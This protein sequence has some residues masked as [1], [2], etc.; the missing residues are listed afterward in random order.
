MRLEDLTAIG[1]ASYWPE[2]AGLFV[3]QKRAERILKDADFFNS[4]SLLAPCKKT[5]GQVYRKE[6]I[7][8]ETL[9]Y[10]F[11][12]P[13]ATWSKFWR[14][15]MRLVPALMIWL[16]LAVW[17]LLFGFGA[18]IDL[19]MT[20]VISRVL[21]HKLLFIETAASWLRITKVAVGSHGGHSQIRWVLEVAGPV[22]ALGDTHP[23][24]SH[25][26]FLTLSNQ[27]CGGHDLCTE[28]VSSGQSLGAHSP[29]HSQVTHAAQCSQAMY[30]VRSKVQILVGHSGRSISRG[31]SQMCGTN[32][33]K[34]CKATRSR[35]KAT[36]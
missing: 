33:M 7:C 20:G 31:G 18:E 28:P 4:W 15:G 17:T 10:A 25:A 27:G 5:L 16:M 8:F 14:S 34:H 12:P 1:Q 32:C 6:I 3:N 22:V 11:S 24:H 35:R 23:V 2:V 36:A 21:Q 19:S 26:A 13:T 30:V 9:R 29:K